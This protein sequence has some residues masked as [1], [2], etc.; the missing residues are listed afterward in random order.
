MADGCNMLCEMC[1]EHHATVHITNMI[2]G[3]SETTTN[4][5]ANCFQK[6]P[7]FATLRTKPD[8]TELIRTGKCNYCGAPPVSGSQSRGYGGPDQVH[9]YC[10]QCG[11]DLEEFSARP[12]NQWEAREIDDSLDNDAFLAELSKAADKLREIEARRQEFMRVKV[13]QRRSDGE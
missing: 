10:V 4:V 12:E 8:L 13:A 5:C 1:G 2:G 6:N 3:E 9:L 7:S 11:K